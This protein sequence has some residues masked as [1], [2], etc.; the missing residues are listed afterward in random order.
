MGHNSSYTWKGIWEAKNML[1]KGCQWRI[2]NGATARIWQD[3]YVPGY[4]SLM[5]EETGSAERDFSA[6]E[7]SLIDIETGWWDVS[8]VRAL[9]NPKI[10]SDVMKILL[11]P[12][13]HEDVW[14]WRHEKNGAFSVQNGYRF[15]KN[16]TN[17]DTAES[18]NAHEEQKMW[19]PIWKMRVP[20]KAGVGAV[21]R[22]EKGNVLMA[23][24][25]SKHELHEPTSVEL[26]AMLR[27]LKFIL[28][29]GISKVVLECDCLLMVEV[30]AN[31]EDSLSSQ[32][33]LL[34]EV[35]NLLSHFNEY[36]VQHVIRGGNQVARSVYDLEMWMGS[37]P[38]YLHQYI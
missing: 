38:S 9:F 27:G 10:A 12:R 19:K 32:G 24:S 13:Q 31:S 36:Q 15:F 11:S 16:L 25:K 4:Q 22:D 29:L 20:N 33:N 1:M 23:I 28:H 7:A 5:L 30:L 26:L 17:G 34:K 8:R 2:G 6:R 14:M 37:V 35:R 3:N 21:L 18:S